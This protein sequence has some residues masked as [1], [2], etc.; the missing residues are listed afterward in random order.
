MSGMSARGLYDLALACLSLEEGRKVVSNDMICREGERF[1][2][3]TDPPLKPTEG[4]I[5]SNLRGKPRQFLTGI[6]PIRLIKSLP[7]VWDSWSTL[8]KWDWM[9]RLSQR[10][11]TTLQI[12]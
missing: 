1:F 4:E 9:Y 11:C 12:F 6:F 7:G 5:K 8:P 10:S 3:L 2:V